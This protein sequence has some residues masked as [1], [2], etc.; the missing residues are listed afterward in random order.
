MKNLL[1]LLAATL[2]LASCSSARRVDSSITR[3]IADEY[4]YVHSWDYRSPD[5]V[6]I[7]HCDETGHLQFFSDG[8]YVDIATQ[9]HCHLLPD[10]TRVYYQMDYYCEGEWK[11][12]GQKFLFNEHTE[13]FSLT[14]TDAACD[15]ARASFAESISRQNTPDTR[16]WF[17][18]DIERLDPEWFIWS[19]TD[20]QGRKTTWDMHRRTPRR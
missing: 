9:Q 19:Y 20:K 3:A 7:M 1:L 13:N 14:L 18:F 12:R 11:V 15:S 8:T 6:G 5:G 10:S 4:E 16:R 17:T 2:L